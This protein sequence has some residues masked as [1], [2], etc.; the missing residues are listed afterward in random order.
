[1]TTIK[2][3]VEALDYTGLGNALS[4]QPHLANEG[5]PYDERN[6]TRAH[7]LHRICDGVFRGMFSDEQSIGLAKIFLEYGARI[8]GDPIPLKDTPLI[9]ACS[10]NADKLAMFYIDRGADIHHAGTHGGTALHWAAWTGRDKL[11]D[12]LIQS[13]AD[14]HTLCVDFKN[15]PLQWAVHGYNANGGRNRSNQIECMKL[16][17]AAGAE[18]NS[19]V[20][21]LLNS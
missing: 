17:V 5:I 10:L 15:T 7:P 9:A 12:K 3:L 16:L 21:E 13:G 6:T 8:N 19:S 18:S 11:V 20:K 2:K 14:V 1:M 4:A